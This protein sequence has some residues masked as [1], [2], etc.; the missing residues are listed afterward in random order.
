MSQADG[1]KGQTIALL[2]RIAVLLEKCFVAKL[3]SVNKKGILGAIVTINEYKSIDMIKKFIA[4]H[5]HWEKIFNK[6]IEFVCEVLP[7]L[8]ESNVFDT[9]TL[10]IPIECFYKY[11]KDG[12]KNAK[13]VVLPEEQWP[14]RNVDEDALWMFF[15]NMVTYSCRYI[16]E[17]KAL[18]PQIPL[19]EYVRNYDIKLVKA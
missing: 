4:H 19:D 7:S 15:K 18:Y 6:D 10:A 3:T 5:N 8:Y 13:G 1:F 17:N 12:Y 16:N 9:K 2:N 11:K 14:V